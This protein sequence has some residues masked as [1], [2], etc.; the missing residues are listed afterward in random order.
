MRKRWISDRHR[1]P[2]IY[3]DL[4]FTNNVYAKINAQT[5]KSMEVDGKVAIAAVLKKT[6]KEFTATQRPPSLCRVQ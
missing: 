2:Y 3:P 4:V 6:G 1:S 5:F